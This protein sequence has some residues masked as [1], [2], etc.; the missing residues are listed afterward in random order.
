MGEGW[1]ARILPFDT[2]I[3][4][5]TD[6]VGNLEFRLRVPFLLVAALILWFVYGLT[7]VLVWYVIRMVLAYV[8]FWVVR[9]LP[10]KLGPAGLAGFATLA[11]VDS[12]SYVGL[13]LY[14]I[15]FGTLTFYVYAFCVLATAAIFTVWVRAQSGLLAL[16]EGAALGVCLMLAPILHYRNGHSLLDAV[17]LALTFA[18]VLVY[19]GIMLWSVWRSRTE[20]I[21]SRDVAVERARREAVG[22]LTGGVAH[23]FNNLLT[24]V[25]GNLELYRSIDDPAERD[26]LLDQATTAAARG[27]ELTAQLLAFSR[28]LPLQP[29]PVAVEALLGEVSPLVDRLL[30]ERHRIRVEIAPGLPPLMVDQAQL[31]AALMNLMI[32][33]RDAMQEGGEITVSA[34]PSAALERPGVALSV[35]DT[36][37][38]I[39]PR[40]HGTVFEPYFTT[41][42]QGKGS[43]LGLSMVRGLVDQSGGRLVLE[44]IPGR[45]TSVTLHLPAAG[46]EAEKTGGPQ[47]AARVDEAGPCAGDN[48]QGSGNGIAAES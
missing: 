31:G 38:G 37:T 41:K 19:F 10:R 13:S 29:R 18:M 27:A 15:S 48:R 46:P 35:A 47:G 42:P 16:C 24:V 32:N 3:V 2:S 22:Q 4:K 11:F 6:R 44:S 36:G 14:L 34:L 33:A 9:R 40:L 25:L 20:V 39:P 12:L 45:G 5:R 7:L 17:A 8:Y 23:D 1:R 30:G 26:I 28:K 43:G 21:R